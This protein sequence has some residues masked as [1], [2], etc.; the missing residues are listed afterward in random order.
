MKL[1][2]ELEDK[3]VREVL[4]NYS[5]ENLPK[6][7]WKPIEGF[8]NYE[9]SNYGRVKSLSRLSHI[10]L[11]VEHW[12]SEKIRK[13]LFTKQYNNYL[14]ADVYNVH[15][16]LSL[17]G[18]KYT[19]S[20]ARLV[21]YHFVEKFDID[22][23][24]IIISYKDNNVFHKHSSNLEKISASERR[25]KIFRHNR[26][27]NVYVDYLQAV[28]QYTAEGE[29][30]AHFESIYD[31][32]EK[33]GI[34]CESIMDVINKNILTSGTFRWFLRGNPPKQEDFYM[35]KT[36]DVLNDL[37]NKH[38]WEK[39]GKPIIDKDSPPSCFNLSVIDL[40]GEYWVPIPILGFESRFVLSN[41]GRVKRLSGWI[42]SGRIMF[43]QEKILSQKLIINSEK[44]YSL[45]CTLSSERKYVRVV[46]S[47]LLYCC[48]VEKF[49]LSDRNLMVVNESDPLWD[50]DIS[51]LSLHPANYVLK[52]KYKIE[53]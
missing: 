4:Y 1:P 35:V 9:I 28:S 31:V 7:Q 11:G 45:S 23:R 34:A 12:V 13:L 52:K 44:T 14:K 50:I 27:R 20:V 24:S 26:A 3:Y 49:D 39:L 15:C 30:I 25:L 53:D 6:E 16:G 17:E 19:R 42:S 33:L 2:N 8:E 29:F 38:L 47:K 21:Y 41:K 40:P 46:I 43:L 36:A 5:L 32:E 51:K 18:R 48:F 22:D 10:S 37:L